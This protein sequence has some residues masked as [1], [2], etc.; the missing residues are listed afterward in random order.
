M[1]PE[2]REHAVI[3]TAIGGI[4]LYLFGQSLTTPAIKRM[5]FALV[6]LWLLVLLAVLLFP[7]KWPS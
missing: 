7:E 4:L 2:A 6:A 3:A 1:T 5:V